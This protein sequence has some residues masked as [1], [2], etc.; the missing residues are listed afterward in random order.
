MKSHLL[1][2]AASFTLCGALHAHSRLTIGP[3]G[4]RLL[5]IDSVQTPNAEL[6]VTADQRFE[7][8]FLDKNRKP[9]PA[10]GRTLAVTAG[11]RG[12]AKKLQVTSQGDGFV[13][14]PAPPGG[15]FWVVLQVREPGAA[16]SRPFRFHYD[17]HLCADC[18]KPEWLCECGAKESG[19][20]ITVPDTLEGLWAEINQHAKELHEGAAD[21]AYEA[22]DEVTE[23]FPV[24]ASALPL[25]TDS[26]KRD[27]AAR[28]V[29]QLTAA[30]SAVRE[31]FAA[32][33]PEES[34]KSLES[35][36]ASLKSL[37]A[38]YPP[39]IA[40]AQLKE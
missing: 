21:K 13:T 11:E 9:L 17:T 40:N 8:H 29:T 24:L 5:A 32:R 1:L 35:V 38:L 28:L 6:K 16:K 22:I 7:V 27:E 31:S 19:R 10:N 23:A 36:D 33:T 26:T 12:A 15:D 30:L 4:G 39:E 37:K 20:N 25:K 2:F 3:N 14:E 18:K 34:Q